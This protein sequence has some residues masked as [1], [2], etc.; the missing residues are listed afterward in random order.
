[1]KVEKYT[2]TATASS[3]PI[4]IEPGDMVQRL[5]DLEPGYVRAHDFERNPP[6]AIEAP[7]REAGHNL[8]PGEV[9]YFDAHAGWNIS[10]PPQ[11]FRVKSVLFENGQ[12]LIADAH[13]AQRWNEKA[14]RAG[15]PAPYVEA[16]SA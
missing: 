3:L 11:A 1:M 5:S 14:K 13:E 2:L 9:V 10:R 4:E 6:H 16:A 12:R 8:K 15:Q 7:F